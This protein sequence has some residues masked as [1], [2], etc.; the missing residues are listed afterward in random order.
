MGSI[1]VKFNANEHCFNK[2]FVSMPL[3]FF[4]RIFLLRISPEVEMKDYFKRVKS[5]WS[6]VYNQEAFRYYMFPQIRK[7]WELSWIIFLKKDRP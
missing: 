4:D 7:E 1:K 6:N 2:V 5:L 3:E